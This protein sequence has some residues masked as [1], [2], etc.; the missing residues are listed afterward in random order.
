M[1]SPFK[2][3]CMLGV[4]GVVG[5]VGA[6]GVIGPMRITESFWFQ[7]L[8]QRQAIADGQRA[9]TDRQVTSDPEHAISATASVLSLGE[10]GSTSTGNIRTQTEEIERLKASL[11]ELRQLLQEK[12]A[13]E[14]EVSRLHQLLEEKMMALEGAE[15]S[16]GKIHE[17][18]TKITIQTEEIKRLQANLEKEHQLLQDET[19]KLSSAEQR[20]AEKEEKIARLESEVAHL[21]HIL[22]EKTT[23]LS[24][25]EETNQRQHEEIRQMKTARLPSTD[26]GT[27][28]PPAVTNKADTISVAEVAELVMILNAQIEQ[29]SSLIMDSLFDQEMSS[30]GKE[31][32]IVWDE[33]NDYIGPWLCND[34]KRRSKELVVEPD[35]L[36]MQITLQTGLV[37]ACSRIINDW[38]PPFWIDGLVF[39][40]TYSSIEKANGQATAD[41]WKALS[42]THM[43]V[44]QSERQEA[45]KRYL[46]E[47]LLRLITAVGGSLESGGIL[48]SQY[49]EKVEDIVQK[50]V[51]LHKTVSEDI[52]SMELATYTSPSDTPFDASKM[53][54][55]E[56]KESESRSSRVVCTVEMGLR[57]RKR[58][59]SERSREEWGVTMK[60]KVVLAATLEA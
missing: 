40:R 32:D 51:G 7:P 34:L 45:N 48:L 57:C 25:A 17:F 26:G 33:L 52:T 37:N 20:N 28:L 24:S 16:T 35:P 47:V 15:T 5:I 13:L 55:T 3:L 31:L 22:E 50:A 56:G 49:K 41:A 30:T 59:E 43:T 60:S 2:P 9:F 27:P 14:S 58:D 54:D 10:E 38:N 39:S 36:I 8:P 1:S 12:G 19:A 46:I 6:L 18:K 44:L 11:E 29:A 4:F 21:N 42:R 23:A 53:E